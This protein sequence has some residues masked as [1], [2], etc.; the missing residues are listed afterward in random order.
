LSSGF[1]SISLIS[2]RQSR[3]EEKCKPVSLID[4]DTHVKHHANI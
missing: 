3:D 4:W 2:G 1:Y